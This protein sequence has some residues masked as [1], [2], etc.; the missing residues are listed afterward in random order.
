MA[1]IKF[2]P[3]ISE[4]RGAIGG[5]VFS[6]NASGAYARKNTAPVNPQ[7]ERQMTQRAILATL[8]EAWRSL[9]QS[10]QEAWTTAAAEFTTTNV[11]GDSRTYTG[12][13]LFM[14]LNLNR[15]LFNPVASLLTAPPAPASLV[16]SSTCDIVGGIQ[17]VSGTPTFLLTVT[18]DVPTLTGERYAVYASRP[19]SSGISRINSVKPLALIG[20]YEATGSGPTYDIDITARYLQ[21]FG[22]Q[23]TFPGGPFTLPLDTNGQKVFC[24]IR[25]IQTASGIS[26]VGG[27]GQTTFADYQ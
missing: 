20:L 17:D 15:R 12:L 18:V 6:R 4:I 26:L 7:T 19:V 23:Q 27:A 9:T 25:K 1:R 14:S 22:Q 2:G 8:S 21:R 13:Q 3:M 24:Q 5:V 10:M 16:A 11:F